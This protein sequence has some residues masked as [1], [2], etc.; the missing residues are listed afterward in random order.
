MLTFFENYDAYVEAAAAM[1]E[2]TK[3]DVSAD[4]AAT[5]DIDGQQV[6]TLSMPMNMKMT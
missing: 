4:V 2:E 5:V 1:N 3:M 6:M